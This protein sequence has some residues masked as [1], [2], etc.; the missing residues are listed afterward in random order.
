MPKMTFAACCGLLLLAG[1][2]SA[3]EASIRKAVQER[4]QVPVESVARTPLP[5]IYEV[6][7]GGDILYADENANYVFYEGSLIDLKTKSNLTADRLRKLT[8][9]KFDTLPLDLAFKKV[10]GNGSRKMAYFADPNC[11]YCKRFEQSINEVSDVTVYMFLYPILAPDSVEKSKAVWCSGNRVKAWD[12]W[13]QR[14]VA[15]VAQTNCDTPVQRVLE[16]GKKM[17]IH[18]TPTLIFADG[19]RIP[20]TIPAEQLRK[21]LDGSAR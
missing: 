6:F 11:G 8:A 9:I 2:V 14:G 21:Q 17:N 19:S 7:A 15:P 10:R 3:D 1:A 18:G 12:D 5:G 16:Y 13:M 20:G 4:L